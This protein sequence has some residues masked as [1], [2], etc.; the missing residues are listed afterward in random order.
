MRYK[1]LVKQ[2]GPPSHPMQSA[3]AWNV[4]TF[5]PEFLKTF[6]VFGRLSSIKHSPGAIAN[7]FVLSVSLSKNSFFE[8]I[9]FNRCLHLFSKNNFSI[10]HFHFSFFNFVFKVC[11]K[12]LFLNKCFNDCFKKC[13]SIEFF[14]FFF[15]IY[16]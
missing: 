12:T 16:N 13:F 1:G 2:V 15:S 5:I 10:F 9:I 7:T 14:Y 8:Q 4:V 3:G 11:F 6:A